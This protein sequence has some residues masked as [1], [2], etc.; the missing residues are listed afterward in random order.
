M[1]EPVDIHVL[2]CLDKFRGSLTAPEACVAFAAG[3]I[4][5]QP[6]LQISLFPVADGGEGTADALIS[7]GYQKVVVEASGP[8]GD[9]VTAV[10]A[11]QEDRAV[12][13]LAQVAG[14]HL[15][16][17]GAALT[18]STYGVGQLLIAALDHGCRELI[19][20]VGGSAS[21]DGGAGMLQALGAVLSDSDGR[22]LGRG[23]GELVRL[24]AI[25]LSG[26][27]PRLERSQI[28]LAA[29]VNNVLLGPGGAA[30]VFSP[31]KGADASQVELLENGLKRLAELVEERTGRDQASRAGAGA[32]GG[33]GFAALVL[34]AQR[35][36][37][38]AF[39]LDA[40][41]LAS[42]LPSASLVVVG[43]GAIDEQ[44]LEGKAP[45]G[46]AQLARRFH[47][48]VVAVAG[49][50]HIGPDQLQSVGIMAGYALV[51]FSESLAEAMSQAK[52]LL[53][54]TGGLVAVEHLTG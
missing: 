33:A 49:Q 40:L 54:R 50:I 41:G 47:V 53:F 30:A 28:V 32:A 8:T 44:S 26:L 51:D 14:L 3:L 25:D 24:A 52:E 10:L 7:I 17:A 22:S 23:G 9:A 21:T 6:R 34:G 16:P 13:E 11:V 48:P 4:G 15:A 43:E 19:L 42:Q 31:Q 29:D 36:P 20:A 12:I 39:V 27:D 38:I 18:A 5:A 1:S 2:V 46:I 45:V 37:G 35:Q